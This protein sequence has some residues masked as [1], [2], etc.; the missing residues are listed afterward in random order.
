VEGT[1]GM[2]LSSTVRTL[3]RRWCITVP[4]LMLSLAIAGIT[5]ILIP[6]HYTSSGIAVLVQPKRP[7][8]LTT[9][10]PLLAFDQSMDTS[11]LMLAEAL[12]TPAIGY[13][14]GLTPGTDTF[15][16]K[17]VGSADTGAGTNQPF[18]Y[19]TA[20]SSTPQ[21]AADIVV[22]VMDMARQELADRQAALHVTRHNEI[23]LESVVNATKPKLAPGVSL[24]VAGGALTLGIIMTIIVAYARDGVL[25]RRRRRIDQF[26]ALAL[27]DIAPRVAAVNSSRQLTL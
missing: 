21:K 23:S 1:E 18:V 6:P 25:A 2:T 26:A 16:V 12:N 5:F 19:V 3:L 4:G 20:R 10:N 24:A 7:E 8:S 22:D 14:L 9:A 17:N 15:T 27:E 13:G 11:A